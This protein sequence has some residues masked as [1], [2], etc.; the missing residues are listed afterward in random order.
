[1][2]R[3]RC[4]LT[5]ALIASTSTQC[6]LYTDP[7]NVP[8]VIEDIVGPPTVHRNKMAT[9][10]AVVRDENQPA[11]TLSQQWYI[12]DASAVPCPTTSLD[13]ALVQSAGL[14]PFTPPMQVTRPQDGGFCLWLIVTDSEGAQAFAGKSF[15]VENQPPQARISHRDFKVGATTTGPATLEVPLYSDVHLSAQGSQDPDD[16]ALTYAFRVI[17][18]PGVPEPNDCG[19]SDEPPTEL[20]RRLMAAGEYR[21]ELTV[22]DGKIESAPE[23]MVV[24][25]LD[26]APPCIRTTVP[27]FDLPRIVAFANETTTFQVVRIDDDGDPFPKNGASTG[28]GR[29]A[30]YWRIR[31]NKAGDFD[32]YASTQ[33]T[34]LSYAPNTFRPGEVVEVRLDY[35]D[36]VDRSD[37]HCPAEGGCET[38]AGSGCWQRVT[39]TVDIL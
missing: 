34:Q 1:M 36:R 16:E 22:S 31:R 26:D 35:L 30:F 11:E 6:L 27:P 7:I 9:F 15:I 3:L 5:A 2:S 39:W 18:P 14:S 20:C 37:T 25:A 8:P 4:L 21:F 28:P 32:R 12:R 17:P 10:T 23:S 13:D 38:P 29:M 33:M 19:R 24:Q